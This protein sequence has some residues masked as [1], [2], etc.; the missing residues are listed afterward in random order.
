MLTKMFVSWLLWYLSEAKFQHYS[1][2]FLRTLTDYMLAQTTHLCP[3]ENVFRLFENQ[4]PTSFATPIIFL[5][6]V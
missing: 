3:K 2:F 6:V 4:P 5:G 1:I